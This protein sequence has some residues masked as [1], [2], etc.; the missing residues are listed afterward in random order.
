MFHS[1][2]CELCGKVMVRRRDLERIVRVAEMFAQE[3]NKY[4][5]LIKQGQPTVYL[6][7][8]KENFVNE[9]FRWFN[10]EKPNAISSLE[11]DREHKVIILMGAT[12]CG[13]STLINGMVNYILGV[14]WGDPFRFKCVREDETIAKNQAHSQTSSVTAYTL[15]HHQGMAVPYSITIIDTPGYG[16]TRG[17]ARDKLITNNIHRFLTQ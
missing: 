3:T 16:D 10:V 1:I 14:Q 13:K 7:N 17:I 9:D 8:A 4:A 12:G 15:R 2:R 6:L 5:T 11:D